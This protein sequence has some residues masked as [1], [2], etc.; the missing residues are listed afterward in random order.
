M[1]GDNEEPTDDTQVGRTGSEVQMRRL[2]ELEKASLG[3]L[4][5]IWNLVIH[6]KDTIIFSTSTVNVYPMMKLMKK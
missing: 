3:V 6:K 4:Q 2:Q 1:W 5:L